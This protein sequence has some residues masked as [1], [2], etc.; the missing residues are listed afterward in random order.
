MKVSIEYCV[1]WN[2][3]PTASSL[4]A[5]IEK[6]LG[7]TPEYIKSGGGVFEVVSDDKLIFSK[8]A[9]G[10]FPSHEEIIEKLKS[11]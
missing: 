3:F 11:L 8:K 7:I 4:A 1:E 2:Y 6:E 10:R 5:A 9:T